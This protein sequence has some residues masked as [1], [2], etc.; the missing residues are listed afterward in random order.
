MAEATQKT[1]IVSILNA[2]GDVYT[3]LV[4]VNFLLWEA[5]GA[6]AGNALLVS[7]SDGNVIWPDHAD[8]ANYKNFCPLKNRVNGIVATTMA[9]GKLYIYKETET[10]EKV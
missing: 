6:G 3:G 10:L 7:D 1:F 2:Q 8:G 9:A 4:D 5:S